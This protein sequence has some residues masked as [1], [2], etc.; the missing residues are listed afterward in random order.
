PVCESDANV[1]VEC[2]ADDDCTDDAAPACDP[3]DNVCVECMEDA[4]C[5]DP[6]MPMCGDDNH[7]A[8]GCTESEE[9][10]RFAEDEAGVCDFDTGGC[11]E[12]TVAEDDRDSET[13]ACGT[14]V[15]LPE[16][17]TCD[18]GVSQGATGTCRACVADNQ[19]ATDHD[20]V[21]MNFKGVDRGGYCLKNNANGCER[22]YVIDIAGETTLSGVSG[23][24]Y[25]GI[26][27][28]LTTS[29]AV[30]AL[31][32]DDT[33]SNNSECPEGGLCRKVGSLSGRCT[34]ECS[35]SVQCDESPNPGSTCGAGAS[36]DP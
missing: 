10:Q 1:C 23:E 33:C 15:C 16:T 2:L 32:A 6:A 11:V 26:N 36:P 12:C 21:P 17:Q 24:T 3:D 4:D 30:R 18:D 27:E 28:T 9:C 8:A 25:C 31:L 13:D 5:G 7:C 20:C 34:Y 22:P 19:C 29:E 14:G 35:G